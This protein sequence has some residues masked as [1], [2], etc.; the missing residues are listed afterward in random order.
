MGKKRKRP[1]KDRGPTPS[2]HNGIT[3]S[4]RRFRTAPISRTHPVISLYYQKVFTLRDYLLQQLPSTSKS[5]RRRILSLDSP[6]ASTS[7]LAQL[8][9]STLVGV[10]DSCPT[11]NSERQKEYLSFTQSQSR[12]LL[13][14]TDT[15]PNCPQSE[16]CV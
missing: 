9:D 1:I 2:S 8:L 3:K 5:R 12:S 13:V 16:V 4:T 14:S 15:G 6:D 7:A 11:V 10:N